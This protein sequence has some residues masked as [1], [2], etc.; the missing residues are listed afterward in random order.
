MATHAN[1]IECVE[2]LLQAGA[3]PNIRKQGVTPLESAASEGLTE[4]I[5]CLLNA[6]ADPNVTSFIYCRPTY[7]YFG[8]K[9]LSSK[10]T[11]RFP[12]R[13]YLVRLI[14]TSIYMTLIAAAVSF[15]GDFVSFCGAIM[16]SL[17]WIL[18]SLL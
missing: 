13:K 1:S 7:A 15:F 9:M 3:D 2:L 11:G 18:S 12:L 14:F 10:A 17:H 16:G 4:I 6:G 5:K 8:E